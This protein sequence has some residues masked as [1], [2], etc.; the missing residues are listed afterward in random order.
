MTSDDDSISSPIPKRPIASRFRMDVIQEV[1]SVDRETGKVEV[2]VFPDPRRY[3]WRTGEDGR[4]L[5]DKFD[6]TV[7]GEDLVMRMLREAIQ[8][9]PLSQPQT[10]ADAA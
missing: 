8:I 1:V 3:E 10:L 4:H 9:Q 7:I 6:Q 2:H 5:F